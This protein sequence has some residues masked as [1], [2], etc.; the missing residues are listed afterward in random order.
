MR[1]KYHDNEME[2][3]NNKEHKSDR[4]N[5][6]FTIIRL[7]PPLC[8]YKLNWARRVVSQTNFIII[9]KVIFQ[10]IFWFIL[11]YCIT[12]CSM[13]NPSRRPILAKCWSTICDADPTLNQHWANDTCLMDT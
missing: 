7:R 2:L 4:F 10:T 6:T 11:I 3:A 8:T 13:I 5:M 9:S 1:V 12:Y